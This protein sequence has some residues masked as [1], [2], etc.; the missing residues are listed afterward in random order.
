M[1]AIRKAIDYIEREL[2]DL[3]DVY[4]EQ[5]NVFSALVGIYGTKALDA[6]SNYEKN[7]NLD[8]AQQ[9]F[10]DVRFVPG[11]APDD[12]GELA[13]LA[14][15]LLLMDVLEHV[16]DDFLVLSR[17]LAAC[18]PGCHLLVTVPADDA[19]W[20][21]HDESFGHYRRY[22]RPRFERLWDGLPVRVRL[23]SYFN[24]RLYWLIR[25][26]R[27]RN[28]RRRSAAGAAGTDFW[29]PSRPLN[30]M[31]TG[32]FAGEGARLEKGIDRP[33]KPY[34][35]GASLIAVLRREEGTIGQ[36]TKPAGLLPDRR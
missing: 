22:D 11:H 30:T 2:A 19:L 36:R 7:R 18:R 21:P 31:L 28:Q 26:I 35:R 27:W 24:T 34:L 13:S 16:P 17:L 12:L 25:A 4:H 33:T 3:V 29:L 6:V 14:D 8:T 32:I 9:R 10:P 20:S 15:A 23:V 5:A 1:A